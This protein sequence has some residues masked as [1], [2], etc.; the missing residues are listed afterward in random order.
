MYV[1]EISGNATYCL[2]YINLSVHL[3]SRG[4]LI[5]WFNGVVKLKQQSLPISIKWD[6]IGSKRKQKF[7]KEKKAEQKRPKKEPHSAPV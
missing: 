6:F 1:D 4:D 2:I 5:A 7:K 3:H